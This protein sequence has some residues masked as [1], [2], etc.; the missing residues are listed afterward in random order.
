VELK[1]AHHVN[2]WYLILAFMAILWIQDWL[3]SKSRIETIPYS[4]FE[5]LLHQ[6]KLDDLQVSADRINGKL[7]D[8]GKGK[9][10]QFTTVR[11]DP[12][13]AKT[14]AQAK[15]TFGG[16]PGPGLLATALGWIMPALVFIGL[17]MWL[18]RP[19]AGG[20]WAA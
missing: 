14:L 16:T 6:G 3:V 17:W 13:L 20:G 2:F 11:V 19:M 4:R 5:E 8:T 15:V 7:K 10:D 9:P 12:E 18:V 1:R